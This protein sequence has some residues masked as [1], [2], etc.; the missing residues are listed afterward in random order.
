MS[1]SVPSS[2]E[3]AKKCRS[4]RSDFFTCQMTGV[5]LGSIPRE[6]AQY[7]RPPGLPS[8]SLIILQVTVQIRESPYSHCFQG[9]NVPGLGLF[10]KVRTIS[11]TYILTQNQNFDKAH[12]NCTKLSF[13]AIPY[14]ILHLHK[15]T[16]Y[17]AIPQSTLQLK[18]LC[19]TIRKAHC[20][21]RNI[22]SIAISQRTLHTAENSRSIAISQSTLQP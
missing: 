7:Y 22:R 10:G 11:K 8:Q 13:L 5:A 14:S 1:F 19:I 18:N 12:C 15:N 9:M 21:C 2:D 20:N 16:R 4:S 17:I 3:K 6:A